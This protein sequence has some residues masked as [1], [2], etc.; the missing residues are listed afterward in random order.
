MGDNS[1]LLGQNAGYRYQQDLLD[2]KLNYYSKEAN[3]KCIVCNRAEL[4]DED[5]K[6]NPRMGHAKNLKIQ[7]HYT[8]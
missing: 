8:F 3:V 4:T 7:T 1:M 6:Y 2:K 5:Y